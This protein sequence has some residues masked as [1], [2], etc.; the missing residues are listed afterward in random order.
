[1]PRYT[2]PSISPPPSPPDGWWGNQG[3]PNYSYNDNYP[4]PRQWAVG[5]EATPEGSPPVVGYEIVHHAF[6]DR[7]AQEQQEFLAQ[8]Y[9]DY[10]EQLRQQEEGPGPQY[11]AHLGIAFEVHNAFEN[12]K[13]NYE[14]IIQEMGG[15]IYLDILTTIGPDELVNS[16]DLFFAEI[17]AKRDNTP[18]RQGE[19]YQKLKRILTRLWYAKNEVLTGHFRNEIFTWFQFVM[20]QPESFQFQYATYFI[21][22]TISA[23]SDEMSCV[24]GIRERLLLSIADACILHCF[25]FKKKHKRKTRH[26]AKKH[27]ANQK[28]AKATLGGSPS[29]FKKCDNPLYRRLIHLFKKEVPDMNELTKEWSVIFTKDTAEKMTTEQIRQDF[30][31]FMERKYKLYNIDNSDAIRKRAVELEEIFKN[32]EF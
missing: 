15:R 19:E 12:I 5:R 16:L 32:K 30:I 9:P 1:M 8:N 6:A 13:E 24:K 14:K 2:P 27:K 3:S 21:E 23:Y 4:S 28:T 26:A 18:L 11:E 7:T 20:R 29:K 22:D 17:I 25:Q 31:D 10:E